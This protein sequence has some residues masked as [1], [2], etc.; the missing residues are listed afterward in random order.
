MMMMMMM[1]EILFLFIKVYIDLP[2]C[3]DPSVYEQVLHA[4]NVQLMYHH[5]YCN[6]CSAEIS[7]LKIG[8]T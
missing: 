8:I 4:G 2:P 5:Y 3:E 7:S 6:F 1:M